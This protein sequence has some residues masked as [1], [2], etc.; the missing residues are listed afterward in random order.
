[1]G[2]GG[3][4]DDVEWGCRNKMCF[5]GGYVEVSQR[6]CILHKVMTEAEWFRR[7]TCRCRST[8]TVRDYGRPCGKLMADP[9]QEA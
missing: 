7:S 5:T 4:A 2:V 6:F 8:P 3:G 9:F 1:M